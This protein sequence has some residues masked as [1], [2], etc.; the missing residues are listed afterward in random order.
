MQR[1]IIGS[2]LLASVTAHANELDTISVTGNKP[3]LESQPV[4][5]NTH[6]TASELATI[7]TADS[8][9]VIKYQPN[10]LV[11]KRFIG[12][13]NGLLTFR[14]M[15]T[16]QTPRA[17]V[18]SDGLLLSNFLGANFATAPR[19]DAI[20]PREIDSVDIL[21]GPYSA[22]YSG[23]SLG[24]VVA[25]TTRMPDQFEAHLSA[26][27]FLQAFD[28]YGTEDDY[29]GN[30]LNAMVGNHSGKWRVLM[31]ASQLR[32]KAQPQTYGIT[33][34]PLGS[35]SGTPVTGAA[36][37]SPGGYVYNAGPSEDITEQNLKLKF[38]YDLTESLQARLTLA[39]LNRRSD[40]LDPEFYLHDNQGSPVYDGTVNIDGAD[41]TVFGQR[42]NT[43]DRQDLLVGLE[44]EGD[45]GQGWDIQ[46]AISTY[47]LLDEDIRISANNYQLATRGGPGAQ[48]ED[49]GTGWQ[50]LDLN[51]GHRHNHR[52]LGQR[53]AFG[54]HFDRYQLDLASYATSAW[55]TAL[56]PTLTSRS[57][58]QTQTQALFIENEWALTQK[59][60][61]TLGGRQEWWHASQG[62]LTL[63]GL[64]ADYPERHETRFSPKA[65]LSYRFNPSWLSTLSVGQA[66]RFATVG[67]LYQGNLDN[68]GNFNAAFDPNLKTED[69]LSKN[70]M[71]KRFFP[72]ATITIN[73]WENDVDNTIFR[74]TNAFTGI[75]NYQNI[76]W[77][78]SRGIEFIG[79]W[80][81]LLL[82][83]LT[84]DFNLS[85]TQATIKNNATLPSSRGKQFPGVP[86]WRA[87]L[88]A[89][90][91]AT[92]Q[93]ALS[94]GLR[95]ASDAYDTLDNSDGEAE[96]FGFTD[97]YL[98]L[99][100]RGRYQIDEQ[101]SLALGVD[102][103][104]DARYYAYYPYPGRT[105]FAELHWDY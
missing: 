101:F 40:S 4:A 12:D 32:N 11:R 1:L 66:Y 75:T 58:G 87:N 9:D 61:L 42:M 86:R 41:Y 85:Y 52:W 88:Q 23:N 56:N 89:L 96:G 90:Y 69:G 17:L 59:L 102:N 18:Y 98:V 71:L 64:M 94:S 99:D 25:F 68:T 39:Y 103:L 5:L 81:R 92:R 36:P 91:Q 78:L 76:D 50:T 95:Y 34:S 80:P 28:A 53:L 26:S 46:T 65:S 73:L 62:S 21:Y 44:L 16:F 84:V 22:R 30:R 54:Y 29:P 60:A 51:L 63:P 15:H 43:T 31:A 3:A 7:N 74:Q 55:R 77:V 82:N 97:D 8:E 47:N 10:L 48:I 19:W 45:L 13:Q 79:H 33:G 2:L 83:D 37:Y 14:D 104:T 27:A 20:Q 35:N 67:E 100:L 105:L 93:V 38:G 6:I 72:E 70:L 24:G 49:L 57:R